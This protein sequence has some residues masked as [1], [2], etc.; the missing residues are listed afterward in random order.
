MRGARG[1]WRWTDGAARSAVVLL[2]LLAPRPSPVA[3]QRPGAYAEHAVTTVAVRSGDSEA[4]R[5]IVRQGRYEL[6]LRADTLVVQAVALELATTTGD[7]TIR[8]DTD[9]F[10]GGRWKLVRAGDGWRTVE[11]PFVPA[12]LEDVLDLAALMDD[13]F[14]PAPPMA[15]PVGSTATAAG[16]RTWGRVPGDGEDARFAW[17]VDRTSDTSRVM[18]DAMVA[19]LHERIDERGEG[20]WS[21]D[22]VVA[23]QRRTLTTSITEVAGRVIRARIDEEVR[24]A[25]LP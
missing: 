17:T 8:H 1:G 16:G 20:R 14:P 5:T 22:G 21:A 6:T 2:T 25:R 3:A 18:A 9:G 12:A 10:V 7:E 23:W 13:F 4:A 15:L 11:L 24:V 19:A